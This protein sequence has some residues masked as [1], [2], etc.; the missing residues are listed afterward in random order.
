M[1]ST[2]AP[3]DYLTPSVSRMWWGWLAPVARTAFAAGRAPN[4][5]ARW[6]IAGE[7]LAFRSGPPRRLTVA[8]LRWLFAAETTAAST[9]FCA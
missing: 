4:G 2:A 9:A 7:P 1:A 3:Y 8:V 6:L 5:P